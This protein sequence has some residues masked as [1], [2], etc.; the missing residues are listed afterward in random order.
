MEK[1]RPSYIQAHW[2][3]QN[4]TELSSAQ[5]AYDKVVK[6]S[7]MIIH[8][9]QDNSTITTQAN[10]DLEMFKRRLIDSQRRT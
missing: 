10:Q 9:P 2:G 3:N 7:R 1:Q 4:N 5:A 8:K 6:Q